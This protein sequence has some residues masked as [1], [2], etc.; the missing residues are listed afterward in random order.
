MYYIAGKKLR[1]DL[2]DD[3]VEYLDLKGLVTYDKYSWGAVTFA[4]E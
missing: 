4:E 2:P 3:K 1:M